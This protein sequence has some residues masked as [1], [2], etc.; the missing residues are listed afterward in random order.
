M[1]MIISEVKEQGDKT[2][3]SSPLEKELRELLRSLKPGPLLDLAGEFMNSQYYK[4]YCYAPAAQIYHHNYAG[5]LLEHSLGVARI[6]LKI[7]ELHSEVDRDLILL[8]ALLHDLGK[9]QELDMDGEIS[10]SDEGKLLG[11]I[12]LGSQMIEKL[13]EG[14]SIDKATRIKLIHMIA[15]HHGYYEWQSPKKPMFLEAK[16]LHLADM[17]DAEIWKFKSAQ[18]AYEGSSWS[19]YMKNIGSAVYLEESHR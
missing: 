14:I 18:P 13:I 10:Y 1:T 8:G 3:W 19:N 2:I 6:A 7:A 17:M 15:S 12:I 9:I 16:I 4:G 11:H 5:G